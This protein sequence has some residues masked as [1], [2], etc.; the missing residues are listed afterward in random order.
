MHCFIMKISNK[1][2]LRNIAD[3]QLTD[4]DYSLKKKV[5]YFCTSKR[6]L[7]LVKGTTFLF[8]SK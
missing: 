4:T 1:Y 2:E 6:Q 5:L 7:F 8:D 3:S